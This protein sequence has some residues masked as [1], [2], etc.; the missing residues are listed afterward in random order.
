MSE[1][2]RVTVISH[3]PNCL[4]GLTCAVVAARYFAGRR[5]EPI[6]AS[7]REIDDV[8]RAYDPSHPDDEELWIT[9]IS[10]RDSS[11]D[12]HLDSL[13]ARGLNI[14]W[15]DHHKTAIDRRAEGKLNVRFTNYVLDDS[16][17]ASRLLFNHLRARAD[18]CGES[19]PGLV[20]LENLVLLADDVDRWIL[21]VPGSREL[22]LAVRAMSQQDAYRALLALDSSLTYTQEIESALRR[23]QDELKK[24]FALAESTRL[25]TEIPTRGVRVVAA[26]CIDYAGEV[27]DRWSKSFERA[28]FALYDHRSAGISFRRTPDC[29]VDLS[30]LA[31]AFGGGGHPAAAGCQIATASGNRATEIARKVAEALARGADQ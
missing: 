13:A 23:V 7:N 28:V 14:Y 19:K 29:T 4:D 10:W 8:L 18:A 24:T 6:F 12:V 20:A 5:Y 27:A 15:I 25:I 3:G 17:S 1:S 22:A 2:R 9:D 26:E 21:E 31:G 11:T 16:Y 30:R